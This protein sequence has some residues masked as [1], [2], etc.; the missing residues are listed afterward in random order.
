MREEVVALSCRSC[1]LA[2]F[3]IKN[4]LRRGRGSRCLGGSPDRPT[5]TTTTNTHH[6]TTSYTLHQDR[7][8]NKKM[9]RSTVRIVC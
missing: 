7:D 1:E 8:H 3:G 2:E 4:L 9:L 6:I 5:P